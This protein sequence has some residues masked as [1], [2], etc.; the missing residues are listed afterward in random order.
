MTTKPRLS[1]W[2][3]WN[4][5]FGFLGI[6]FGFALQNSNVSR[7]FQTLGAEIDEIAILWIAAPLTGLIVQPIVGYM[8][9]NTWTKRGGR[10]RPY[11]TYGAIFTTL[12]IFIM[13][14]SPALWIA[15]GMLWIMDASINVSMEPFRAFVGDMLDDE[16]STTAFAM[17]SFFI[18]VGGVVASSLPWLMTNWMGISN[19]AAEGVVPQS[20][21]Y[22]FY[23][24][25]TVLFLAVMWTV[26]STKEYSPEQLEEFNKTADKDLGHDF[27]EDQ[28]VKT[29]SDYR[30]GGVVWIIL[31]LI[32]TG[33]IYSQTFDKQLYILTMGSIAFG[34]IQIIGATLKDKGHTNNG[35]YEVLDDLFHMPKT[36]K[37]LGFAQFLTW[38]SLFTMWIY[39][40]PAVADY[41]YGTTDVTSALY[42]DAADY[43][44]ILFA[45]YSGF[46]ALAAFT[47]P[48]FV[49]KT[50][51][52]FAHMIN[53]FIGGAGLI[54]FLIVKDPAWL[55]LSMACV[56]FAWASVLSIPYAI[57]I[58]AVPSKKIG[59]Y[60][61]IFNFFIVLPQILAASILGVLLR[62]IFDGQPIYAV[63]FAGFCMFVSGLMMMRVDDVADRK[64]KA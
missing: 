46:A 3:I 28:I 38:F 62:T 19:V 53:M 11:F 14:N 52:K 26:F 42:N 31:G 58:A 13:P 51:R 24:G 59:V 32:T 17:Q 36:M 4:M 2:Q 50:N 37:Q 8:S 44:G 35:F 15:A 55:V 40:T 1:F 64:A 29:A 10:R 9:D 12:A 54:S 48:V 61:G 47:I 16:Q 57:L 20:V 18:G 30:K 43:V 39:T 22:S 23:I 7:I 63:T 33:I 49:R 34:I 21:L 56:G 60:M 6:Q 5:S 27:T 41:H 25:G 45:S